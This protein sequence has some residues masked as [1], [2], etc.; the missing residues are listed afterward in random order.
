MQKLSILPAILF[1][2]LIAFGQTAYNSY[3]NA[4]FGYTISYPA[5]LEPQGEAD[6]GDGQVFRNED[7][8]LR[9]WGSN[10]ALGRTLK[11][12]Y[13]AQLKEYG[14]GVTYKTLLKNGFVI[15]GKKGGK[16]FY[17]KT[18]FRDDQFLTFTFYYKESKRK[19]YD[20]VTARIA[21]S[22]GAQ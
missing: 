13:N 21:K 9:V 16:I 11:Q 10:N 15:S 14:R 1:L 5:Q 19:T 8:E 2:S 3:S 4:R 6:N 20:P 7:A 18:I 12:E 17:Q 22:F